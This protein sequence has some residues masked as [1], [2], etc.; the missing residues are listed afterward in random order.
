MPEVH[1]QPDPSPAAINADLARRLVAA[2]FPHWAHLPVKPVAVSGWDNRTFHLGES[3]SIRLPSA[4]HY[5]AQV[6]KEQRWLPMLAPRLP[7]PIPAPLAQGKPDTNYPW[8]WS[9]YQWIEGETASLQ[10]IADLPEFAADLVRFLTALQQIDPAGGPTPGQ[11]NFY[12]GES[13]EVYSAETHSALTALTGQIDTPAAAAV[14]QA[15][16][17]ARWDGRPVWVHGDI[18]AGNLLVQNGRLS[19]VIDFGSSAVGDPAC[20]LTI[21]WTLFSGASRDAFRS[22]LA[23]P[24]AAWA[25]ARGWALWKALITLLEYRQTDQQKAAS[26]RNVINEVLD[27]FRRGGG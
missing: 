23:L 18:A 8:S 25:R 5:V 11:H 20:D 17:A 19:A 10:T 7:L 13:L 9:V 26:A 15:A 2:Q 12:R 3:M 16:L 4:A 27:D 21:A 1:Q 14:W 6:A 24:L 22:G